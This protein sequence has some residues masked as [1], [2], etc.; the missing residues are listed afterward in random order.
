MIDC[1]VS[2][3]LSTIRNIALGISPCNPTLFVALKESEL[4]A[5]MKRNPCFVQYTALEE[6]LGR[7]SRNFAKCQ[8]EIKLLQACTKAA[9]T[10]ASTAAS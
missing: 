10:A 7:E 2:V 8:T 9:A 1:P 3:F 5:A 6:C 4:E